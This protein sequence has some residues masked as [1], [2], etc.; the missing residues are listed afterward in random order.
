LQDLALGKLV[1]IVPFS[2]PLARNL[3]VT[4]AVAITVPLLAFSVIFA[5]NL[6]SLI[7]AGFEVSVGGGPPEPQLLGKEGLTLREVTLLPDPETLKLTVEV[8][9]TLMCP[10]YLAPFTGP[11]AKAM[12]VR[13]RIAASGSA[14]E[15]MSLPDFGSLD[16]GVIRFAM[17]AFSWRLGVP[18]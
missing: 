13:A 14:A 16:G 4:F 18:G 8:A 5:V 11:A 2:L 3:P 12:P 9:D 7:L 17:V 15:A 6:P 10:E 1:L